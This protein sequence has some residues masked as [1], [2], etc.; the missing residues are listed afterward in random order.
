[1]A[2]CPGTAPRAHDRPHRPAAVVELSTSQG[3]PPGP[4]ADEMLPIWPI[5]TMFWRCRGMSITG[6]IWAG[7]ITCPAPVHPHSPGDRRLSSQLEAGLPDRVD[8][9]RADPAGSRILRV[10]PSR[11]KRHHP[12]I[13]SG[14]KRRIPQYRAGGRAITNGTAAG[15]WDYRARCRRPWAM[16]PDFPPTPATPFW[17]QDMDDRSNVAAARFWRRSGGLRRPGFSRSPRQPV[18][19]TS[20]ACPDGPLRA[21]RTGAAHA[22]TEQM[23]AL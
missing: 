16:A 19:A 2:L 17:V 11:S 18:C 21:K 10:A 13:T 9:A 12:A 22:A 14:V 6:T 3:C 7:R 15:L 20:H 1:M 5:A 4:P 8:A 23:D